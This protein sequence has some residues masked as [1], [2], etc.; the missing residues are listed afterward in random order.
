MGTGPEEKRTI[1]CNL[2]MLKYFNYAF[3]NLLNW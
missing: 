3:C 2:S 1:D